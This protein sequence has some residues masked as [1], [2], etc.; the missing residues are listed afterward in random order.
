MNTHVAS[1]HKQGFFHY[2]NL[3]IVHTK[4][5][6]WGPFIFPFEPQC[7]TY[8]NSQNEVPFPSLKLHYCTH[9]DRKAIFIENPSQPFLLISSFLNIILINFLKPCIVMCMSGRGL[10]Q[11]KLWGQTPNNIHS[12]VE[13]NENVTVQFYNYMQLL[14]ICD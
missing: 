2:Q 9:M 11:G 5:A 13:I 12:L 7:H 1:L 14:I 10:F 4:I 8:I 6:K 3:I